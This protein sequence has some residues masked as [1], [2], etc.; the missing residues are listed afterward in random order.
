MAKPLNY[1]HS[2]LVAQLRL[3][4]GQLMMMA[5]VIYLVLAIRLE[6]RKQLVLTDYQP[7]WI[8]SSVLV[9]YW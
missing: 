7:H 1:Q 6:P 8:G 4:L 9:A 5:L 3:V 2:I